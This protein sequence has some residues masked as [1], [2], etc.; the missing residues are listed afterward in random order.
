MEL[1]IRAYAK[2]RNISEGAV[3]K[4]LKSGRISKN[5]NGKINPQIADKE[6]QTN[7][8]PAQ[9]KDVKEEVKAN[10]A[11]SPSTMSNV[12]SGSSYQQSRAIK[13]IY[14]A[15]LTKLQ[16]EKESKKLISVDDVKISAFNL[17]R[18]TRDR[19]LNIPDRVIPQL[20]NKSDIHEMKE[21]LKTELVK[22][23]EELSKH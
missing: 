13:E 12:P 15:K 1:S 6:W 22:A 10:L 4:A 17:A 11:V 20:V 19:I 16:F 5:Q 7:T 8:D 14:N 3:R 2:H 21:I 9:I 18:I 23:L